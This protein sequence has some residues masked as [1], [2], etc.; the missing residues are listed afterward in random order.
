MPDPQY[1]PA[2]PAVAAVVQ[3]C[4]ELLTWLIPRL[5]DFLRARKLLLTGR[6]SW[7][8][9]CRLWQGYLQPG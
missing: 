3:T 8:G 1:S 5:D 6:L 7:I 4:H 2:R 9:H